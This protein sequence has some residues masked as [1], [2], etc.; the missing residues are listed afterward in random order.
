M[1]VTYYKRL[2]LQS[3]KL[4]SSL[5]QSVLALKIFRARLIRSYM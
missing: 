3:H 1:L 5:L 4:T 2:I